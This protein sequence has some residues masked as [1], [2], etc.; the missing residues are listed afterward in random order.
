MSDAAKA[1]TFHCE[2]CKLSYASQ[3]ELREHLWSLMHHV[4]LEQK[5]KPPEHVCC[6]CQAS[7]NNLVQYG[8]HLNELKHKKALTKLREKKIS[9]STK[10]CSLLSLKTPVPPFLMPNK[11]WHLSYP[12]SHLKPYISPLNSRKHLP[13]PYQRYPP[14]TGSGDQYVK[15]NPMRA[16]VHF[17]E[18]RSFNCNENNSM[19][20]SGQPYQR[21]G[22][23]PYHGDQYV[24]GNPMRAG[25]HFSE[26]RSFNCNE[27]NSMV[28][29]G[30]PHQR[31]P[32][33]IGHGDQ[34]GRGNP[35]RAGVHFS[36]ERISLNCNENN[37]VVHGGDQKFLKVHP[38]KQNEVSV[39]KKNAMMKKKK[40][41]KD[42][43]DVPSSSSTNDQS[44]SANRLPAKK[45]LVK[46][47]KQSLS[48]SVLAPRSKKK[49]VV[50]TPSGFRQGLFL[51]EDFQKNNLDIVR[52]NLINATTDKGD[53]VF[54]NKLT[55][56]F[57]KDNNNSS[58]HSSLS[59][60][61][62]KDFRSSKLTTK[63]RS[64]KTSN[65]TKKHSKPLQLSP[66]KVPSKAQP[67]SVLKAVP[68]KVTKPLEAVK[69]DQDN[70]S[71]ALNQNSFCVSQMETESR[72][73]TV[74]VQSENLLRSP[75]VPSDTR[76]TSK[77]SHNSPSIPSEAVETT[78]NS[79]NSP[80]VVSDVVQTPQNSKYSPNVPSDA[81]ETSENSNNS[82]KIPCVIVEATKN[83]KNLE[84]CNSLSQSSENSG[85]IIKSAD[86]KEPDSKTTK[87]IETKPNSSSSSIDITT[88]KPTGSLSETAVSGVARKRT[89]SSEYLAGSGKPNLLKK[90][91]CS[92][93]KEMSISEKNQNLNPDAA[94]NSRKKVETASNYSTVSSLQE[95]S[96][97][98]EEITP[99]KLDS[100][101]VEKQQLSK[102]VGKEE[103]VKMTKLS[104]LNHKEKMHLSSVMKSYTKT[105][106]KR[107]AV[108]RL[109]MQLS[110]IYN[111]TNQK[112]N[113]E[114]LNLPEGLEEQITMLIKKENMDEL[115]NTE[116]FSNSDQLMTKTSQANIQMNLV[117]TTV[118]DPLQ[119][120]FD[121][122]QSNLSSAS[123]KSSVSAGNKKSTKKS[124]SKNARQA[125]PS[126]CATI[127][128]PTTT[129]NTA[130]STITTTTS[131]T[132]AASNSS[133]I[134][135]QN[136]AV[137]NTV[138]PNSQTSDVFNQVYLLTL[139]EEEV[140]GNISNLNQRIS[141]LEKLI[142]DSKIALQ[143]CKDEQLG[144]MEEEQNI[145]KMRIGILKE[146]MGDTNR[147][148]SELI[149][150]LLR[151]H[152]ASEGTH[153]NIPVP[154]ES[155]NE[156]PFGM[157][158]DGTTAQETC[159]PAVVSE[160]T[161]ILTTAQ[162]KQ[163]TLAALLAKGKQTESV[164]NKLQMNCPA[165]GTRLQQPGSVTQETLHQ[166]NSQN[167]YMANLLLI[168]DVTKGLKLP[169]T[170]KDS[171]FK[172]Q[173][174]FSDMLKLQE[175]SQEGINTLQPPDVPN[176]T[177]SGKKGLKGSIFQFNQED[178]LL[179]TKEKNTLNSSKSLHFSFPPQQHIN[180]KAPSSVSSSSSSSKIT[181]SDNNNASDSV[182][183]QANITDLSKKVSEISHS[184]TSV[185]KENDGN[186]E[187][188]ASVEPTTLPVTSTF[189]NVQI[190]TEP[191]SPEAIETNP[192]VS[193][194]GFN[195]VSIKEEPKSPTDFG[196]FGL[197]E[198]NQDSSSAFSHIDNQQKVN[199]FEKGQPHLF[200]ES[201]V[202]EVGSN[203][204][205]PVSSEN[206]LVNASKSE[207][208][209]PV[210]SPVLEV[211]TTTCVQQSATSLQSTT[212]SN[213][214]AKPNSVPANHNDKE[215]SDEELEFFSSLSMKNLL[216]SSC[217]ENV[218]PEKC[219]GNVSMKYL[220]S[221]SNNLV[222]QLKECWKKQNVTMNK[223]FPQG[224]TD[225]TVP[226]A[227]V[228]SLPPF[229]STCET[230]MR[231]EN[232]LTPSQ[233]AKPS[234]YI[235][236]VDEAN[237]FVLPASL[238][239]V[240]SIKPL[241][242][243]SNSSGSKYIESVDVN[244][245]KSNSKLSE[246]I[247]K[248]EQ[249]SDDSSISLIII[250]G[251]SS[252]EDNGADK[253]VN[254]LPSSTAP[255]QVLN[256]IPEGSSTDTLQNQFSTKSQEKFSDFVS[257]PNTVFKGPNYPVTNCAIFGNYLYVSYQG[258]SPQKFDLRT[259]ICVKEYNCQPFSVQCMLVTGFSFENPR[260]FSGGA[261]EMLLVF[262]EITG[263]LLTKID[264]M[265]KI[266]T[267][268]EK[269]NYLFI[270]LADG[271]VSKINLKTLKEISNISYGT[272]P[273]HCLAT[274][275]E[276][277]LKIL[278]IGAYDASILIVSASSGLLLKTL[279]PCQ[280]LLYS[281]KVSQNLIYSCSEDRKLAVFDIETGD[282]VR[283][284][285]GHSGTVSCLYVDNKI[286]V[287][288]S[289]D[290]LINVYW[291]SVTDLDKIKP[292]SF[293]GAG[294]QSIS[295][296]T[297]SDRKIYSGNFYGLVEAFDIPSDSSPKGWVC[298]YNKCTLTFGLYEDLR[299]HLH[300]EHLKGQ[301]AKWNNWQ[302][303]WVFCSETFKSSSLLMK[304]CDR[305]LKQ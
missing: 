239:P 290:K 86:S 243:S 242:L 297:V 99:A 139:R 264:L 48:R 130:I 79:N 151:S 134:V 298:R 174:H 153:Q 292:F 167:K 160:N 124:L 89:L 241:S 176:N 106:N 158:Q 95:R 212:T 44:L 85:L 283:C 10:P 33:G 201:S 180:F 2:V 169:K 205:N 58:Q 92:T 109:T 97:H 163:P 162:Q 104:C 286:L 93:S 59:R 257:T 126:S 43:V 64:L 186:C 135:D 250:D 188:E 4:R 235:I 166:S 31:Y 291:G 202:G 122:D 55:A 185:K 225:D 145:R 76:E 80:S 111:S 82:P 119:P 294:K 284:I 20:H 131:T 70:K 91:K 301:I 209:L 191:I 203:T 72:D 56:G 129:T 38:V 288:G 96:N 269:W 270:G 156:Q 37:S 178:P 208:N 221:M 211:A 213:H 159:R 101:T 171:V 148:N 98:S 27:N 246:T 252:S 67:E 219:S 25:V 199:C 146:A 100:T 143:A 74:K 137:E 220:G 216:D 296:L 133:K 19:D 53:K 236:N 285:Q 128:T 28:H 110:S 184:L 295:C 42:K 142:E 8:Q 302:C 289:H 65:T 253:T 240:V 226:V 287:T 229:T 9:E 32:P 121:L 29:G 195:F 13:Q 183:M 228:S 172:N 210:T 234:P 279:L 266:Y 218:D 179:S 16:G 173:K 194:S 255:R 30:Q 68:S 116:T 277:A 77:D 54:T 192:P 117:P 22:G 118:S 120:L 196:G 281:I 39:G 5:E 165:Q 60:V 198:L 263:Q 197:G 132:T 149:N 249:S 155:C 207:S 136:V 108:P 161:G 177:S 276:G 71:K 107:S 267:F 18:E 7:S 282:L 245:A 293:Y 61:Q 103:L 14:G 87:S 193:D 217:I 113:S 272:K 200:P 144:L 123:T 231:T 75:S 78:K 125:P 105:Q 268:H 15:G 6:L 204:D 305:H 46:D 47:S 189:D 34:Y 115:G 258:H 164:F 84:I 35:M 299:F 187:S 50:T 52:L 83:S 181:N 17:S 138:E 69:D 271:G 26:E 256:T 170:L 24:R 278:C 214:S 303:H 265:R 11:S 94:K 147:S 244:T 21:Y 215:K 168:K 259:A 304:H 45:G 3:P 254:K 227:N 190:K 112:E 154:P 140:C 12:F 51:E 81:V 274:C 206:R 182:D 273:I 88:C 41:K 49:M 90:L 157:Q 150:H 223:C 141:Y 1:S 300:S 237:N 175:S 224:Q 230:S 260:V 262:N 248:N 23:Q 222:E 238:N 66:L 57:M 62:T 127:C 251:D 247:S 114:K 261:S 40:I 152:L 73:K 275:T 63:N 102:N 232:H 36:E 233:I 280:R